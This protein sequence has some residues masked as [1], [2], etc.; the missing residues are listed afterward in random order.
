MNP[1][2]LL[3]ANKPFLLTTAT[4]AK[5]IHP[6]PLP[7]LSLPRH[8]NPF[9]G[10]TRTNP[11][12]SAASPPRPWLSLCSTKAAPKSSEADTRPVQ[13]DTLIARD[14]VLDEDEA[15]LWRVHVGTPAT[16][17]PSLVPARPK[18]S[19]SDQAFF[20]L[21]FIACTVGTST[22]AFVFP[23]F[24]PLDS[25]RFWFCLLKWRR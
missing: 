4:S 18:L 13:Q 20:L 7:Q 14:G 12:F 8:T 24:R 22:F 17:A 9:L 21:A 19:L 6:H 15:P 11:I 5:K 1:A 10:S 3:T 16:G 2:V 25:S 23:L